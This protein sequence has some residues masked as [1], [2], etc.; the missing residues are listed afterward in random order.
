M[1]GKNVLKYEDCYQDSKY[2]ITFGS[3]IFCPSRY[4]HNWYQPVVF[5]KF[6]KISEAE[7]RREQQRYEQ[8]VEEISKSRGKKRK[9]KDKPFP[10]KITVNIFSRIH[11]LPQNSLRQRKRR[12]QD[13]D[14]GRD[15]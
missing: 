4:Y 1:I 11:E 9:K 14:D 2:N 12:R 8:S 5:K 6:N 3:G 7:H 15:K 13:R 10:D